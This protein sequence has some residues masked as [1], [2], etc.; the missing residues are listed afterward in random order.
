MGAVELAT[1]E[2]RLAVPPCVHWLRC[3]CRHPRLLERPSAAACSHAR[4]AAVTGGRWRGLFRAA[5]LPAAAAVA[6]RALPVDEGRV[7]PPCPSCS[8]SVDFVCGCRATPVQLRLR[9]RAPCAAVLSAAASPEERR[10]DCRPRT[11]SLA[12][13]TEDAT[14]IQ[15]LCHTSSLSPSPF[16]ACCTRL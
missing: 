4:P 14:M 1:E 8:P 11:V 9:V 16:C 6:D 2:Q 5:A 12:R 15:R 7:V 13:K 3:V 10:G